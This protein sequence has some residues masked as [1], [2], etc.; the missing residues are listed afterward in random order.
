[1]QPVL[2][3]DQFINRVYS[4]P[5]LGLWDMIQQIAMIDTRPNI[6]VLEA[7]MLLNCSDSH[8]LSE[9]LSRQ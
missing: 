8:L 2:K 9:D 7:A 3:E 1:L 4:R 5:W 6:T